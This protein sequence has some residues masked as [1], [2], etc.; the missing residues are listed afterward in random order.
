MKPFVLAASIA[1]LVGASLCNLRAQSP[2]VQV[3]MRDGRV[4]VIARD[5]SIADV[6]REWSRVGE[7]K[8][9]NADKMTAQRVTL[10]IVNSGERDALDILLR[11]AAGY[12]AAPRPSDHPGPSAYDRITILVSSR[13]PAATA[14]AAYV[15]PAAQAFGKPSYSHGEDGSGA[16]P[17]HAPAPSPTTAAAAT[18]G[19]VAAPEAEEGTEPFAGSTEGAQPI[20]SQQPNVSPLPGL[21]PQLE[22][23][24]PRGVKLS[25]LLKQAGEQAG[26]QRGPQSAPRPGLLPNGRGGGA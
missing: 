26:P 16:I 22:A 23:A 25:D 5:A 2:N 15:D 19:F 1:A 4:T 11:A 8:I 6:M 17:Q 9:V 18:P 14:V 20:P 13:A 7:T 3:T 10:E 21:H 12:I 24:Q